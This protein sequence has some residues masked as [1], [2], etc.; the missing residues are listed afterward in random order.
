MIRTTYL[1]FQ[2]LFLSFFKPFKYTPLSLKLTNFKYNL[3]SFW[4]YF[5]RSFNLVGFSSVISQLF[6]IFLNTYGNLVLNFEKEQKLPLLELNR[7]VFFKF[8][9]HIKSFFTN[10]NFIFFFFIQKLNKKVY[11]FSNYKM[12]RYSVKLMYMPSYRRMRRLLSFFAKS[13]FYS[14]GVTIKKRSLSFWLQFL[15]DKQG[16]FAMDYIKNLHRHVF[17][18]HRNSLFLNSRVMSF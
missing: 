14:E 15:F 10:Y 11:K 2:F 16:L 17:Y 1:Q 8:W 3:T 13:I 4:Y 7:D 5:F 18:V 9:T 12:S 6:F